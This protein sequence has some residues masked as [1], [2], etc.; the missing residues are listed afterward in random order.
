VSSQPAIGQEIIGFKLRVSTD[1]DFFIIYIPNY[2]LNQTCI[3]ALANYLSG[4][5]SYQYKNTPAIPDSLCHILFYFRV[6]LLNLGVTHPNHK[7]PAEFKRGAIR[8]RIVCLACGANVNHAGYQCI[9][10]QIYQQERYAFWLGIFMYSTGAYR[11]Y[12][13]YVA[14]D[15]GAV[16]LWLGP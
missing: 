11:H 1:F 9:T 2:L 15:S 4:R 6:W 13:Q 10:K 12:K 3:L 14:V 7:A 16:F 5:T 8:Y